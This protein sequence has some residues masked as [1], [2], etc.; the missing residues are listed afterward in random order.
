MRALNYAPLPQQH[1]DIMQLAESSLKTIRQSRLRARML[2]IEEEIKTAD[3]SRKMEL[4]NQMQTIMQ[5]L[6][7]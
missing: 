2:A 3:S 6:E 7:E 4:Y 1:E 5:T